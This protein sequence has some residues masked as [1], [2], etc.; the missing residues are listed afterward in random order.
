MTND[1]INFA[2]YNALQEAAGSEFVVELVAAF[3][4]EAPGMFTALRTALDVGDADGFRRAAH[5]MK[6]NADIFGARALATP[7]RDLELMEVSGT[8][9]EVAALMTRL[10]TE[11][12]RASD[13]LKGMQHG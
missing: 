2:V 12:A 7:A 5:S 10:E 9:P 3:L 4:E 1:V 8:T 13:A 6:S 11:F